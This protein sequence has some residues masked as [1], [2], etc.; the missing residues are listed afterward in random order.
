MMISMKIKNTKP[1]KIGTSYYFL[2]PKQYLNNAII[3]Q[4]TAYDL[5]IQIT[6]GEDD[7]NLTL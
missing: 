5:H 2:I 6:G 3:L 4:D 1:K 7:E